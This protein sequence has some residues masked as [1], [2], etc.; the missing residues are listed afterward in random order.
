M[1]WLRDWKTKI[2]WQY[3]RFAKKLL[4]DYDLL[5]TENV[6]QGIASDNGMDIPKVYVTGFSTKEVKTTDSYKDRGAV[7]FCRDGLIR[8]GLSYYPFRFSI[9]KS[10]LMSH[11]TEREL[12]DQ[13]ITITEWAYF[14]CYMLPYNK[15]YED[16]GRMMHSLFSS[17]ATEAWEEAPM[18]K[19]SPYKPIV[20]AIRKKD[21]T[22]TFDLHRKA[23]IRDAINEY[24]KSKSIEKLIIEV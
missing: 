20:E 4:K 11:E 13:T 6:V 1:D 14:N 24:K 19:Y 15:I 22:K 17:Y 9:P 10:Q 8:L 16:W 3:V 5:T 2:E 12:V 21:M 23:Q 7:F 18:F